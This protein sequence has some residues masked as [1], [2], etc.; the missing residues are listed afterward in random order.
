MCIFY[1]CIIIIIV[2]LLKQRSN[3][4]CHVERKCLC[5]CWCSHKIGGSWH[6]KMA[7]LSFGRFFS[8]ETRNT[9]KHPDNKMKTIILHKTSKNKYYT[10]KPIHIFTFDS[11]QIPFSIAENRIYTEITKQ[12][13]EET[14]RNCC[15]F[16]SLSLSLPRFFHHGFSCTWCFFSCSVLCKNEWFVNWMWV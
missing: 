9:N 5:V 10:Y 16:L 12:Q 11:I 4:L 7:R 1:T 14:Y 3:L 2:L 6:L 15:H 13:A 8:V